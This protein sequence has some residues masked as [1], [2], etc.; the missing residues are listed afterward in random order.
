MALTSAGNQHEI[1]TR[2]NLRLVEGVRLASIIHVSL[3]KMASKMEM[4]KTTN[5]R[6]IIIIFFLPGAC[7]NCGYVKR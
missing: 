6:S 1:Q 7:L 3:E 5:E 2:L 4:I